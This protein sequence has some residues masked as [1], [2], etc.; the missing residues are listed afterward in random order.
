MQLLRAPVR[1]MCDCIHV[2]TRDLLIERCVY[3]QQSHN[4][5]SLVALL[6]FIIPQ[7]I[8]LS[9]VYDKCI[10]VAGRS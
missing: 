5:S 8:T 3:K 1:P 4:L 10:I 6:S 2:L 9:V 7:E